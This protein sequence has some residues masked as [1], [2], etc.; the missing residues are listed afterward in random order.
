[1]NDSSAHLTAEALERL[2]I[3]G[4]GWQ[5]NPNHSGD[6]L[7]IRFRG[8]ASLTPSA[9]SVSTGLEDDEEEGGRPSSRQTEIYMKD[10]LLD[11]DHDYGSEN[12]RER[13]GKGKAKAIQNATISDLPAE[14]LISVRSPL[15]SRLIQDIQSSHDRGG[16]F[17]VY[18]SV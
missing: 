11:H 15:H 8:R 9:T 14:V 3:S 6:T 16:C 7:A 1:M 5:A 10:Y 17:V 4:G 13:K 12:D 2:Q 18:Q